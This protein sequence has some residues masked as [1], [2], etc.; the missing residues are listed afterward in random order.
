MSFNL[1]NRYRERAWM[2][3]IDGA[4]VVLQRE[5]EKERGRGKKERG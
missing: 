3:V 5:R 1:L 2:P 4:A